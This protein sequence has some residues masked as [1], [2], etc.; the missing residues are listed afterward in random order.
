MVKNFGGKKSKRLG[1]KHVQQPR[2]RRLRFPMEKG[3]IFAIVI[4]LLGHD[5]AEV[6]CI[7]DI[8]RLCIIRK[9]FR[10]RSKRD[11]TLVSGTIV[12]VGLRE[13]EVRK[14][15]KKKLQKCDLLEVYRSNEVDRLRKDASYENWGILAGACEA[16]P[17]FDDNDGDVRFV[18]AETLAYQE[19]MENATNVK[20]D[21]KKSGGGGDKGDSKGISQKKSG[22]DATMDDKALED[23]IK[24]S[25]GGDIDIDEI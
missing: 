11:N 3:E 6:K 17:K 24:D 25:L 10:G 13:W 9:K 21:F 5:M 4:K 8:N 22:A 19:M 1:R 20:L 12:L 15:S 16:A 18:D 7:D 2:E 14:E 23:I